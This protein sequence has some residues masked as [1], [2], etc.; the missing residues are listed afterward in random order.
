M[1]RRS[2]PL[3][4]RGNMSA[5][6]SLSSTASMS[7]ELDASA[8]QFGSISSLTHVRL[9]AEQLR[10]F[11]DCLLETEMLKR[12]QRVVVNEYADRSLL[13]SRCDPCST[14]L[15]QSVQPALLTR[16]RSSSMRSGARLRRSLAAC[17]NRSTVVFS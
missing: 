17:F 7:T 12:V 9:G 15:A 5:S 14:V 16:G 4:S 11:E 2:E 3:L 8:R 10:S 6:G 13:G 1:A